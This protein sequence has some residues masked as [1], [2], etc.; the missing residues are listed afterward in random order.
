MFAG[1]FIR[2]SYR[3]PSEFATQ[4]M[5]I[6]T[7]TPYQQAD[8]KGGWQNEK[9]LIVHALTWNTEESKQE[10]TPYQCPHS[11]LVIASWLRLDNRT[12]LCAALNLTK[13]VSL[14]DPMLVIAAYRAWG[15]SCVNRLEGDFS[16]VIYDPHKHECFAARDS[17]GVKP[18][19]YYCDREVFIFAS[20]AAI[21]PRLKI[22]AIN[23]S[24]EWIA[25]Y[26]VRL[27]ADYIKTAYEQVYKLAPAHHMIIR[28]ENV[29]TPQRYFEFEDNSPQTFER[30]ER[31][32]NAYREKFYQAVEDRINSSYLIG[33]ESSGG[34]DSST[35]VAHAADKVWHG[36]TNFHCFGKLYLRD[37]P[38]YI[39]ETA[40]HSDIAFN[41]IIRTWVDKT[42]IDVIYR[43]I[44]VLGYPVE[45][46]LAISHYPM[47]QMSET[48]G[49]RTLLSGF[50]GDQVVTNHASGLFKELMRAGQYQKLYAEL[51]YGLIG[52][53]RQILSLAKQLYWPE[54]TLKANAGLSLIRRWNTC[55]LNKE[56]AEKYEIHASFLELSRGK[57][58]IHKTINQEILA[59]KIRPNMTARLEGG[60]LLA[61][62]YKL[63][64]RW[65][66]LDRRLM[67]QYLNTPA[68]EKRYKSMGRYL[69]R[70]ANQGKVA[71]K[72]LWKQSKN[73]GG[74]VGNDK[75]YRGVIK[76]EIDDLH[77]I[78]RQL[79]CADTISLQADQL[80]ASRRQ[81]VTEKALLG[82]MWEN[83]RRLRNIS[84][85]L[86]RL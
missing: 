6:E 26:L 83:A 79:I 43:M 20:T 85:W 41:H 70:R 77:P 54:F 72:I 11:D 3:S 65:P 73:L 32:V 57:V 23:P 62:S 38:Q 67:Q 27:S 63:D 14:T 84:T 30:D 42:P 25:H 37:E 19:F 4:Q 8:V 44:D 53:V 46:D 64:Y 39:L 49:I 33:A 69:H 21:F 76:E 22:L 75:H 16:F 35:I 86:Y 7:L 80:M 68:I 10:T 74:V 5:L 61:A 71:E 81:H 40:L 34:L 36:K 1:V 17:L 12:E 55:V 45:H 31:W 60:T 51:P 59:R 66:L 47:Y 15:E 13:S 56:A 48:F 50:G 2:Q 24:E 9:A 29:L 82:L 18:F 52:S 58:K 78:V 28:D